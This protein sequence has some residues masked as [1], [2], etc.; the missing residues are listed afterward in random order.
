LPHRR[1]VQ[2]S[3]TTVYNGWDVVHTFAVQNTGDV[4][5]KI[6]NLATFFSGARWQG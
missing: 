5:L 1:V 2:P 3:E 6:G 4:D